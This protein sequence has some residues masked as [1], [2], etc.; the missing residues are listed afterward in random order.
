MP[1][2]ISIDEDGFEGLLLLVAPSSHFDDLL[3]TALRAIFARYRQKIDAYAERAGAAAGWASSSLFFYGL[4]EGVE[5][6]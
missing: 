4:R 2:S 6:P 3:M 5:S 1:S